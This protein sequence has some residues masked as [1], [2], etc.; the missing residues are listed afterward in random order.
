MNIAIK[1]EHINTRETLVGKVSLVTGSTRALAAAGSDIV[2]N[3]FGNPDDIAQVQANIASDFKVYVAYFP[4]DMSK[5]LAIRELIEGILQSSG[6]LDILVNN[7]GI[8][9]VAPLQDFPP[10]KWDAIL[11]INLSS[12][13][14]TTRLALPAMLQN[15]WGRCLGARSRDL[16][17]QISLR[18]AKHGIIGLTKVTP[19]D[20][21]CDPLEGVILHELLPDVATVMEG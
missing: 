2:L 1:P 15:K 3:G 12:A 4:A 19:W 13:F 9:H 17:V 6:R 5:P 8:Q 11:A 20:D 16:A 14:H 18:P 21:A 7:A 10:E